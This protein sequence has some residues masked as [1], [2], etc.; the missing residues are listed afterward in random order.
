M[1]STLKKRID[2][3]IRKR[4]GGDI[5]IL[6]VLKYKDIVV[7][8]YGLKGVPIDEQPTDFYQAFDIN[9]KEVPFSVFSTP[10][11]FEEAIPFK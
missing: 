11:F 9:G 3:E 5:E 6:N 1:N 10:G 7:C 4:G 8:F 2:E